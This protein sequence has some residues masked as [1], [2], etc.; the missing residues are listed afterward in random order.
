MNLINIILII[1]IIGATALHRVGSKS[2]IMTVPRGAFTFS[3]LNTACAIV[4]FVIFGGF[5][6]DFPPSLYLYAVVFSAFFLIAAVFALL[7]IGA[8]SLAITSMIVAYAP[9]IP[10][11]YGLVFLDEPLSVT[12]FVGIFFLAVSLIL[13]NFE[14]K[15]E[16]KKITLKW[17]V[18]VSLALFGD[19]AKSTMLKVQQLDFNGLYKNEFLVISFTISAIVCLVLALYKE[20]EY[21]KLDLKT[22]GMY[23]ASCGLLTGTINLLITVLASPARNMPASVMFP[24]MSAGGMICSLLVACFIFK[25]KLSKYQLTGLAMG[26]ISIVFLSI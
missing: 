20:R 22:G 12:L 3:V 16:K 1:A 2:Y 5:S 14:Q 18:F 13:I 4:V 7:A 11:I 19:G 15:G 21:I 24:V 6:F 8:G 9:V 10:T 17:I 23:A 26:M 25:E